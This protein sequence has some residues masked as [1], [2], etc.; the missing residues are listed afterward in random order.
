MVFSKCIPVNER[1]L[2]DA[3]IG[4]SALSWAFTTILMKKAMTGDDAMSPLHLTV[5]SSVA[6]LLIQTPAT[7]WEYSQ[8]GFQ[9]VHPMKHG[10]GWY[11]LLYSQ[12]F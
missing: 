12:P 8:V 2:G 9:L 6:G 10:L 4:L 3:L 7:I 11:F 1:L 5:W